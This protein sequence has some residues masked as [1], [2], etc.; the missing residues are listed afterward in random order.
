MDDTSKP[1]VIMTNEKLAEKLNPRKLGFSP[2]MTA[3][4]GAILG[5]DYGVRDA[6]GGVLT[7]LSITSDG[8]IICG[9]TASDGGGAFVGDA[10]DLDRNLSLLLNTAKLTKT[11]LKAFKSIY[12]ARVTDYRVKNEVDEYIGSLEEQ[13][14]GE[15][16]DGE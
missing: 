1:E 12:T 10:S 6:R 16:Q 9:S 15:A 2:K 4:V 5:Y 8:H 14:R 11:E 13:L 7:S 3:L